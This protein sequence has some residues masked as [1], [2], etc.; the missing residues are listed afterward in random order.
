M[1]WGKSIILAFV[2]FTGFI[3][4]LVTVCVRE[5]IS[6]VTKDYYKE[7][8]DYQRQID[9]ITNSAN[10]AVKPA[11]VLENS[12]LLKITFSDFNQVEKGTLILF[13]PSDP[14]MDK[15]FEIKNSAS[16]TQY[17]STKG[18]E[19][20][21]YRARVQWTIGDKEFYIEEVILL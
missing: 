2:L 18:M 8:L 1:N 21:M 4:T 12:D 13:R 9:R 15:Q 10:L 20:G 3:A 19:T 17:F 14:A 6:L 5:D 11:I 7:E 16:A